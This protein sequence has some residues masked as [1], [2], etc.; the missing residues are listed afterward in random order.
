MKCLNCGADLSEGSKFCSYCGSK[1]ETVTPP[2]NHNNIEKDSVAPEFS[3]KE[4]PAAGSQRPGML[5]SKTDSI[6]GQSAIAWNKLSVQ[7]KVQIVLI[8]T[9]VLLCIVGFLAWRADAPASVFAP[10]DAADC[11]GKEYSAIENDFYTAGF[12]NITV[13]KLE[14]LQSVEADKEKTNTVESILINGS[15]DFTQGQKFKSDNE[16]II[17]C[18]SFEKRNVKILVS[19]VSNLI[20]N[21][22]DVNLLLNGEEKGTLTHGENQDFEFAL[23]P[24]EYEITFENAKSSSI[25]GTISLTVDCDTEASYRISCHGD[26]ISVEA[27]YIDRKIELSDN[28]VKMPASASEYKYKNY[29]EVSEE[30]KLLG[31]ES[32][33]LEPLYDIVFGLTEEGEVE[34]VSISENKDFTQGDVFAKDTPI[35][36]TYH[37]KGEND[38]NK[39]AEQEPSGAE[40]SKPSES[41]QPESSEVETPVANLTADNCP[42]LAALLDLRDPSDPS[43]SYFA[44]NYYGQ[45]IEFD[46]CV[47]NM[48]KHGSY[49]T[50]WDVL[51]GAGDYNENSM[52]GPYFH[53][54]DVSYSDMHV[55]GGDSVFAGLNVHVVAEVGNYNANTTLFEL[56][57]VSMEIR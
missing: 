18:H 14:D 2:P 46:G 49:K 17:R 7:K 26:K 57:I 12:E 29:Q 6:K 31:F 54:T 25:K 10:F 5:K 32:I 30:L 47:A 50:R 20:F 39:A 27:L 22:Y 45:V 42:N 21:K 43:V 33:T 24:G 44:D 55:T 19:F 37:M 11:I 53:L 13:E 28:E 1:I 36:I 51:L 48:Q 4:E 40:T 38:P 35:V 9:L 15:A 8:V 23:E 56:D 52:R 16:I 3:P 41:E 34:S